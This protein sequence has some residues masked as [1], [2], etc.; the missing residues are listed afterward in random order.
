MEAS[1]SA[2]GVLVH[3]PHQ[4]RAQTGNQRSVTVSGGTIR[5][6]IA[7]LD[8]RY[9]GLVFHFCHETGELRPYVNVFVDGENVRYLQ[10][11]NTPVHDGGTIH[12]IHSVA[13]G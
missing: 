12:I 5:D 7:A 2:T 11:L 8:A 3:L 9:P 6:V 1:P 4:L 13:G 10:G